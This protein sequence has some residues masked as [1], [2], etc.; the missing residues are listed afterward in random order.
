VLG[1]TFEKL[2]VAVLAALIVGRSGSTASYTVTG[3]GWILP[4]GTCL[5]CYNLCC[6]YRLL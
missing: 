2:V 4:S 1:L 6:C 3:G 5:I